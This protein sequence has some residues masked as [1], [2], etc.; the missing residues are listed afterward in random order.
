MKKR[1]ITETLTKESRFLPTIQ[2]LIAIAAGS[3]LFAASFPNLIFT[4]GLPLL[5]W[6]AFIPVFW[7]IRRVGPIISIVWGALYGYA[8]Y[9]L[10]NYWL[11]VYHPLAGLIVGSIYMVYMAVLFFFLRLSV[12]FFPNRG[13]ILQFLF[14]M[15]YEYLRTLGFLGYSYGIA[16]YSQWNMLPIIQ[17]ADITGVWGVSAL[18]VFPSAYLAAALIGYKP[19]TGIRGLGIKLKT[20]FLK[21]KI[22]AVIWAGFLTFTI[23]YGFASRIDYSEAPSFKAALIQHNTDPWLPYHSD[24]PVEDYREDFN[25]LSRLSDSAIASH[26]DL[27]LVVWSETAFVPMVHWHTTYRP[28][29]SYWLLVSDFLS[30]LAS[31]DVPFIIGNDDGRRDPILN[32]DPDVFNMVNYNAVLLFEKGGITDIYRKLHLV[33]FT[34]HFPYTQFPRIRQAL[35]DADTHF[36]VKGS[37]ATVFEVNGVRFST[38]ICFEDTFGYLGRN[39]VL[40]GADLF[41]NL[42]NDAWANSLPAQM[43]HL[44]MAVFR[45]VENRRSTVRSTASGQ[46]A[47]IDPNGRILSMAEPFTEAALIVEV[48]IMSRNRIYTLYGDYLGKFFTFSAIVMLLF[49]LIRYIMHSS[50]GSLK[51]K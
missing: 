45:S 15:A 40:N 51:K 29:R 17:I 46:T 27:D 23:I 2:N 42:S 33:P 21:E 25:I 8:A 6:I 35:I 13:Y 41:V 20:F 22:P 11:T 12:Q 14:W 43:Q 26:P 4:N 28:S 16:G 37:E 9:G 10:F 39:F 50:K 31:H 34:E 18:V 36:W 38:P 5:A 48:P 30:F 7:M 47:A 32:P 1:K 49:G 44:S 24:N 3:I 19:E